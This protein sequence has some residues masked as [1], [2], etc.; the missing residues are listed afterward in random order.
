[1][2]LFET[3]L[4]IAFELFHYPTRIVSWSGTHCQPPTH[5]DHTARGQDMTQ[6]SGRSD[7]CKV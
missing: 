3:N 5:P 1:M 2:G 4:G 6:S 7:V